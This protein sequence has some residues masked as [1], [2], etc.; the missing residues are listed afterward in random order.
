MVNKK[1]AR[2]LAA[3]RPCRHGTRRSG[4][5]A[6]NLS[7][8]NHAI[9]NVDAASVCRRRRQKARPPINA[10]VQER[11]NDEGSA[12][13]LMLNFIGHQSRT[14]RKPLLSAIPVR[15]A[16]HLMALFRCV[17]ITNRLFGLAE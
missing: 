2:R 17:E 4:F 5:F 11:I 12:K 9:A 16:L 8:Q 7:R 14:A 6:G 3:A 15:A 1:G 10:A 13:A